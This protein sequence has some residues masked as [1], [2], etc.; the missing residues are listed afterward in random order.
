MRR[1]RLWLSG[2]LGR[3][4]LM[5]LPHDEKWMARWG[6]EGFMI[7]PRPW[8]KEEALEADRRYREE[9]QA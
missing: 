6:P 3:W 9:K 1:L 5:V 4:A 8:V 2:V 7:V